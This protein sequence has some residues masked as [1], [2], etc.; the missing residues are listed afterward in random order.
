MTIQDKPVKRNL[1][2]SDAGRM[3]RKTCTL[4]TPIFNQHVSY[5]CE[6]T[7][8]YR[9]YS[10]R[11]KQHRFHPLLHSALQA[12]AAMPLRQFD[13]SCCCECTVDLLLLQ[14][15]RVSL[16]PSAHTCKSPVKRTKSNKQINLCSCYAIPG[17]IGHL[18]ETLKAVLCHN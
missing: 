9:I 2:L 15:V 12:I 10:M 7:W 18:S 1:S 16:G 4:Y 14:I 5:C 11:L 8:T 3:H 17:E 13:L 6:L